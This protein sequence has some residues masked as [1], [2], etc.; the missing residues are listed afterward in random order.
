MTDHSVTTAQTVV[1][2]PLIAVT[3]RSSDGELLDMA[4]QG[5]FRRSFANTKAAFSTAP[6]NSPDDGWTVIL[7]C[8]MPPFLI[9]SRT[10]RISLGF[11]LFSF[12]PRVAET[13]RLFQSGGL[14][15]A[16]LRASHSRS[17]AVACAS[18]ERS[19]ERCQVL[20][21]RPENFHLCTRRAG[22]QD[23]LA[24]AQV[25]T[26]KDGAVIKIENRVTCKAAIVNRPALA[27]PKDASLFFLR[28]AVGA[29]Q[30]FRMKM[31][32]NPSD[33][34]FIA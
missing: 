6:A 26:R 27:M 20:R 7:V 25:A 23:H 34:G 4:V 9:G 33:A 1:A 30:S 5:L 19:G 28:S 10:R 22:S 29:A 14:S 21:L 24:R 18:Y 2:L 12:F 3:S 11:V 16:S 15:R 17:L 31:F 8:A 32:F 13:S